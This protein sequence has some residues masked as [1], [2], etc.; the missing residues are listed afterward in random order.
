MSSPSVS[1]SSLVHPMGLTPI[2]TGTLASRPLP[3]SRRLV[4]VARG[5]N[6]W[7]SRD[8]GDRDVPPGPATREWSP[9]ID[10]DDH[11]GGAIGPARLLE[12]ALE[13]GDRLHLLGVGP[14][15]PRVRGEVDR[16]CL[17]PEKVIEG[18]A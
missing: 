11:D 16:G 7:P 18:R 5:L 1:R 10:L 17:R 2:R 6:L 9:G 4:R 14:E 15:A 8:L 13:V 12:R 3:V